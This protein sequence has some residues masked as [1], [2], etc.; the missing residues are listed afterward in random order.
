MIC[1]EKWWWCCVIYKSRD[2]QRLFILCVEDG[3]GTYDRRKE[4]NHS[5]TCQ[6]KAV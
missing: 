5:K 3:D 6:I 1:E 4:K 2:G